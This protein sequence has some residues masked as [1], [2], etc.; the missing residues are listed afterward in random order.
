MIRAAVVAVAALAAIPRAVGAQ[1]V[2][3]VW[4]K[5]A[6][7]IRAA[8][9]LRAIRDLGLTAVRTQVWED[10]E[11]SDLADTLGIRVLMELEVAFPTASVLADSMGWMRRTVA[12][13]GR[14]GRALAVGLARA[15][16]TRDPEVCRLLRE[17]ADESSLPTYF[18]SAYRSPD[19]CESVVDFVLYRQAPGP[20]TGAHLADVGRPVR[21]EGRE[22]ARYLAEV[23]PG[24]ASA[25][26]WTFLYR[27]ADAGPADFAPLPL[28]ERWGIKAADGSPRPAVEVVR[29]VL[30]AGQ[31]VFSQ[32]P[33][34]ADNQQGS[35]YVLAGW[36]MILIL[37][38]IVVRTPRFATMATRY[39]TA[40]G[41]YRTA[42]S[43]GRDPLLAQSI[44]LLLTVS[45][46][47]GLVGGRAVSLLDHHPGFS[48]VW[49]WSG[50]RLRAALDYLVAE[51]ALLAGSIAAVALVASVIWMVAWHAV[52]ART[53]GARFSQ[54]MV[55]S[56]WPRWP[57]LLTL[58]VIMLVPHSE[59][60]IV[61]ATGWIL[62][63]GVWSTART[64]LDAGRVLRPSPLFALVLWLLSPAVIG[65]VAALAVL[66]GS[67]EKLA[68]LRGLALQP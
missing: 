27:W 51:P 55:L 44:L 54:V 40:H 33:P 30:T 45:L 37:L 53:R 50:P 8:A 21:S 28:G 4:Q 25:D 38:A 61:A 59:T 7:G 63:S 68:F 39:F 49:H 58:P 67:T 11:L 56:I 23:L 16:D 32:S 47:V 65:T 14:S 57:V 15:P 12:G 6:D 5:P 29:G 35:G 20:A 46:L 19:P 17:V 48:A 52:V 26:A 66:A 22:Q 64:N 3:V 60:A 13:I 2:G 43:D 18:V 34:D 1:G 41:I 31:T 36:V 9:D 42:V 24:R 62:L 10:G